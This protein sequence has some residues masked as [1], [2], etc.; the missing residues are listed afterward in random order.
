MI[1]KILGSLVFPPILEAF[2]DVFP[3]L[4]PLPSGDLV[5]VANPGRPNQRLLQAGLQWTAGSSS[6]VREP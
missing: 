4:Q 5:V 3:L 6:H 2:Q 1:S